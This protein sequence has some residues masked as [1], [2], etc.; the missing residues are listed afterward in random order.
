MLNGLYYVFLLR[1]KLI[2]TYRNCNVR[3]RKTY[4]FGCDM[5]VFA[6]FVQAILALNHLGTLLFE[7]ICLK[8]VRLLKASH[9][10]T[11]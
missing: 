7:V 9:G 8:V 11:S 3:K 6:S 4:V 10:H 2:K 1:N 5:L